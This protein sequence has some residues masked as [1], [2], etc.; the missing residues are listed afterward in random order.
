MKVHLI[1]PMAGRGSRFEKDGFTCPK[2]LI[3]MNDMPFFYWA[4][5][6]VR[7][8]VSLESLEFVILQEHVERFQMQNEIYKYFP[9]AVIHILPEVTSGA[10]ITG[11]KGIKNISDDLPIIFNDC[12]HLFK[13]KE[14]Y[15]FCSN[16]TDTSRNIDGILL[17]FYSD[18]PR[19]SFIEQDRNHR[20]IRTVEKEAIS[21]EAV[22]GCYYFKNREVFE[23][24][25]WEYEKDC[26]YQEYFMSGIYNVL[27]KNGKYVQS[28]KT[29]FHV[30]FGTPEEFEVAKGFDKYKELL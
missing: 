28:M 6:S 24:A 3:S 17:T 22:C 21:T 12:D 2:P 9:E 26:G 16:E 19:Y 27:I 7:K 4:V 29:D 8:F 14:F 18:E 23:Q 13:S 1:M 25:A 30:S 15:Q 5:Q 10:V 11:L 20:V